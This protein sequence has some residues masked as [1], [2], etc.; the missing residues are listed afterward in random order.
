MA[1]KLGLDFVPVVVGFARSLGRA[2]PTMDGVLVSSG[3]MEDTLREAWADW[4]HKEEMAARAK[5]ERKIVARWAA[6][7]TKAL[8]R[9]RLRDEYGNF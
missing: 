4:A 5:H 1:S 7:V 6:L 9:K 8:T 3:P 2:V